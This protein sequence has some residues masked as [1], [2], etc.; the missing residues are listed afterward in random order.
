MMDSTST[1]QKPI[2][3]DAFWKHAQDELRQIPFGY[4]VDKIS[5]DF[6]VDEI[7]EFHYYGAKK[8]KIYGLY[9]KHHNYK[10]PTILMFHGYGWHKGSPEE[11]LDW[12]QLGINVFAIDIRGQRGL[13]KDTFRYLEGDKRLMTRGLLHKEQYYLKHV[14]QDGIQ[15][16]DLVKTLDFVDAN[17]MILHGASQGGGIVLALASLKDVFLTFADV[18]SYSYFRGRIKTRNGSVREIA[19]YIE[20]NKLDAEKVLENLD[21]FDLIHFASNIK[22]PVVA[23]VGLKDDICPA[24][25]FM[26]TYDLLKTEKRLYEYAEAG[27][28]GGSIVHHQIKLDLIRE[29]LSNR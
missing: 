22:S 1:V 27:H 20:E 25:Y 4:Q 11:Y 9:L 7:G 28:E 13:T 12:Y 14:Y 23:S 26:K 17:R 5:S 18:P 10:S 19:D 24:R 16:I 8:E 21:Y 2:Q 3:F 6:G 29:R 15:L